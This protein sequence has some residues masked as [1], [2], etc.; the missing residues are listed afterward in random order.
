MEVF[1]SGSLQTNMLQLLQDWFGMMNRGHFLTPVG[2]SDSHDVSR[3]LVGQSR[4]YIKSSDKEPGEIDINKVIENFQSGKV[5]VSMGLLT[6]IT[7]N[8]KYGPGELAPPANKVTVSVQV[9]GPGW[10]SVNRISLYANGKK[11]REELIKPISSPGVKWKG[12]WILPKFKN[13][14]FLVAVAE[15]PYTHLPF[16]PFVKPFQPRS[17]EWKPAVVGCSGAVWSDTDGDGQK[18]SAYKY[19]SDTWKKS[20][21]NIQTFIKGLAS[22][23]E[24]VAVQAASILQQQGWS[25]KEAQLQKALAKANVDTKTG[26]RNF[27]REWEQSKQDANKL[28]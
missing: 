27:L 15:G 26:F 10:T 25:L 1:N 12:S 17:P 22:F 14:V 3:Y 5:S 8:D 6:Q 4:T 16:W 2:S 9:S 13:D 11:I 19:A 28:R 18:T 7:V 21:G 23:D 20:N 24:A